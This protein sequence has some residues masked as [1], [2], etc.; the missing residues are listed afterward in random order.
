MRYEKYKATMGQ[1]QKENDEIDEKMLRIKSS[2]F[3]LFMLE[4]KK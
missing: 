2:D 1:K 4:Q 3:Y